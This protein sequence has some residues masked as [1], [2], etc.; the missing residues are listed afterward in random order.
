MDLLNVQKRKNWKSLIKPFVPS[1]L[2]DLYRRGRRPTTPWRQS[3]ALKALLR[4]VQPYTMTDTLRLSIIYGLA[5]E[6]CEDGIEGDMV[7]CGVCNGGSAAVIAQV[8]RSFPNRRLWL[9]DTFEGIPA[10]TV[11]D[12]DYAQ[13]FTGDFV[14]SVGSVYEVLEKVRFP[15]EQAVFRK[16]LFQDTFKEQLPHKIALLHVDGDWYESILLTLQTFYPIVSDGGVIILD[17]FGH[18]EGARRAFY[19]FCRQ[20]E[21]EPLIERVGYTQ[22]FWRK[23]QEHSREIQNRYN[24]GVYQP[25]WQ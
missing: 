21:I 15:L 7:E 14:G 17:D 1:A 5:R 19:E 9:Y 20:Q 12:G 25:K 13:S 8:I 3:P 16:G 23:G 4:T 11:I 2:I 10:P 18:W 6:V 24:W 22:A